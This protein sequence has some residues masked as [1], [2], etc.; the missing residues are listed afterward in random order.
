[1]AFFMRVVL[2]PMVAEDIKETGVRLL[3]AVDLFRPF[4]AAS[5]SCGKLSPLKTLI[6]VPHVT[7]LF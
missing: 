7:T 6:F 4:V 1:M 5:V 3:K 2:E